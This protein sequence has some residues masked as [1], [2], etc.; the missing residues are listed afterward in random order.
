MSETFRAGDG[1]SC[2]TVSTSRQAQLFL[3]PGPFG[4]PHPGVRVVVNEPN[5]AGLMRTYCPGPTD[6][7]LF[8]RNN[9]VLATTKVGLAQLLRRRSV[10]ALSRSGSFAGPGYVGTRGGSL[11][12]SLT[13]EHVRAGTV[14][15]VAP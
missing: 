6:S 7:D 14:Q 15:E 11:Q 4:G 10:F 5:D 12:F 9:T 2:Q 13:L 1:S 8:G 3:N